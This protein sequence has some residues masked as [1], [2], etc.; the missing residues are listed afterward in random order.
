MREAEYSE[1][2]KNAVQ[3]YLTKDEWNFEFMEDRGIFRFTVGLSGRLRQINCIVDIGTDVFLVYASTP[4]APE[5]DDREMMNRMAEFLCRANFG[6]KFGNFE[7][8]FD[9]G[10]IRYKC[11][12]DCVDGPPAMKTVEHAIMWPA[13][14][15][16]R[17]GSGILEIL[18]TD[19][20]PEIAV[21]KCEERPVLSD[22]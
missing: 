11:Y 18:Y 14:M 1:Q 17:Y 13:A 8:D 16:S 9:D 20:S 6:L 21:A 3:A 15:F 10:E 19:I 7:F 12:V 5:V 2:I 22:E 4:I